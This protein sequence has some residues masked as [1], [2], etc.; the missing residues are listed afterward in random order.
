MLEP[1]FENLVPNTPE[2]AVEFRNQLL[3]YYR[4]EYVKNEYMVQKRR[5]EQRQRG[6]TLRKTQKVVF[7]SLDSGEAVENVKIQLEVI[8]SQCLLFHKL[9]ADYETAQLYCGGDT[10][11]YKNIDLTP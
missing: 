2:D 6:K 3:H 4:S 11:F 5:N 10:T 8:P 1:N 7:T 9:I